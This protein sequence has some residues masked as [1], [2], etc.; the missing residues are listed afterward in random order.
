[1]VSG[2]TVNSDCSSLQS[3]LTSFTNEI[4]GL[5][6]SWQGASYDN[7]S[8]KAQ[9]FASE[10]GSAIKGQMGSFA[11]ACDLYVEY[12]NCKQSIASAESSYNSAVSSN[13]SSNVTRWGNEVASLKQKLS[14]LKTQIE[15]LLSSASGVHLEAS[16][17]SVLS[18]VS[19]NLAGLGTPTYGTFTEKS[20]KDPETG[21]TMPYYLYYPNYDGKQVDG[22]PVM[23]Y[24][25]GGSNNN[26]ASALLARGLSKSLR[27]KTVNPSGIVIVP[28]IHSFSDKRTLPTLKHLYDNVVEEYHADK[29]RLSVSGHSSGGIMTYKLINAYPNYFAAAIP[30][31]GFTQV[32]DAFKY[33][34]VWA[35][36]GELDTGGST[37]NAGAKKAVEQINAI[38]GNATLH[39]YA[40][41]GHAYVQDYTYEGKEYESPDGESITPLEWAYKQKLVTFN[42]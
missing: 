16:S 36:N 20:F 8:A 11:S 4:S 3:Y 42:T 26:S 14:N 37:S 9:E 15:G 6:G 19:A 23:M 35:F 21:L 40:R 12:E 31:S 34:R 28:F 18:N 13:D 33:T 27:E 32:T 10:Y 17:N 2:G 24:M 29:S 1:M 38:G 30:I 5:S 25:H 7:L 39:T 22:L 41:A